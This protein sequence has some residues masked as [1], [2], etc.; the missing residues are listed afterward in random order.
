MNLG[1]VRLRLLS[2]F[3]LMSHQNDQSDN[4]VWYLT[5]K[6]HIY[7]KNKQFLRI[8]KKRF[9]TNA[10]HLLKFIT[11]FNSKRKIPIFHNKTSKRRLVSRLCI[12]HQKCNSILSTCFNKIKAIKQCTISSGRLYYSG[13]IYV[14]NSY[15]SGSLYYLCIEWY[16]AYRKAR[17][18][19]QQCFDFSWLPL[20]GGPCL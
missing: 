6:C 7:G 2:L 14:L 10:S 3:W 1:D 20:T 12:V 18:S 8:S 16:V 13:I 9:R 15:F 4:N 17:T 11:I 5:G 19:Q